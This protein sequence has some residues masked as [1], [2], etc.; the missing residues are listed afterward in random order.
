M[1]SSPANRRSAMAGLGCLM[2]LIFLCDSASAQKFAPATTAN[3]KQFVGVWKGDF[4][5][6][7]F[8]TVTIGFEGDK[9]V[10]TVSHADIEV[11]KDGELTKAQAGGGADDLITDAQVK[12]DVLR[13]TTKSADGSEDSF[14]SE[15]RL[16][17]NNE[18]SMQIVVPPEVP[19]PAPK[20][21]RL[22]RV[23]AKP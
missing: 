18:V 3:A 2:F 20:P 7:P 6:H 11:N 14:Q 5:G 4:H 12:G 8:V 13:I 16:V 23:A 9:L 17:A 10:G 19:A 22:E 15:L 1:F 21:W